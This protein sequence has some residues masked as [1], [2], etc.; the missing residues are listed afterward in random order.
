VGSPRAGTGSIR[1]MYPSGPPGGS[2]T[3]MLPTRDID[4]DP[5]FASF[6]PGM[7]PR[8]WH[9]VHAG[10]RDLRGV[11]SLAI[12]G[13]AVSRENTLLMIAVNSSRAAARREW[14]EKREFLVNS[15]RSRALS[16][17]AIHSR[18]F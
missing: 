1:G 7:R 13:S 4:L 9:V 10:I 15:G 18:S 3:G 6:E 11:E 2:S 8:A 5:A 14:E 16:Q 12:P 17:K